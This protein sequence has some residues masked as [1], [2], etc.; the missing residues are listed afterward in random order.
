VFQ[1]MVAV[2]VADWVKSDRCSSGA[3]DQPDVSGVAKSELLF[4]VVLSPGFGFDGVVE[5]N[6]DLLKRSPLERISRRLELVVDVLGVDVVIMM[7]RMLGDENVRVLTRFCE[8]SRAYPHEQC[9][10]GL[11]SA[12]AACLPGATALEYDGLHVLRAGLQAC[13]VALALWLRGQ[14]AAFG[15][16]VTLQLHRSLSL[17]VGVLGVLHAQAA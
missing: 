16:V 9:I 17:A 13:I 2:S 11:L 15:V 6:S 10:G 12:Q 1:A 5:F 3:F 4:D 8:T 7:P 14:G